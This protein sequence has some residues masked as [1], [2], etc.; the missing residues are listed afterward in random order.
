VLVP[1]YHAGEN[2]LPEFDGIAMGNLSK[3]SSFMWATV[4]G[5]WVFTLIVFFFLNR[6]YK[7]VSGGVWMVSDAHDAEWERYIVLL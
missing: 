1:I 2:G 6:T 7:H 5:L 3:G 4:V